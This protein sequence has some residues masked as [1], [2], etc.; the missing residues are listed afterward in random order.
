M[1]FNHGARSG[2]KWR[3]LWNVF[4]LHQNMVCCVYS[5]ELPQWGNSNESTQHKFHNNIRKFHSVFVF[6]SYRKTSIGTQKWVRIS[7]GINEP[8]VFEPLKFDCILYE[9][10]YEKTYLLI[11]VP[12]KHTCW[13]VCPTKTQISLWTQAIFLVRMKKLHPWLSKIHPVK[14][15]IRLRQCSLI[16]IISGHTYQKVCFLL[17]ELVC[18]FMKWWYSY[19]SHQFGSGVM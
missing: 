7:H 8:S 17:L 19:C 9:S 6:L 3:Y 5:L 12:N 4:D 14:I 15:L 18:R 1:R 10:Q 16:W 11:C 13:Y 2:N